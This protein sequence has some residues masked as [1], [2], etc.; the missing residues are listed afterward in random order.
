MKRISFLI[1]GVAL[2]TLLPAATINVSPGSNTLKTA[3]TNAAAGDILVL[4]DGTYYDSSVKPAVPLT[5]QAAE[6]TSP[7]I[8]LS[9]RI[10]IKADFTLQ[11]V[12]VISSGEVIRMIADE[13]PYSVTVTDCNM[14]GCPNYFIRAYTTTAEAPYI[15]SLTVTNCLF[16]MHKDGDTGSPRAIA[17]SKMLTQLASLSVSYCTFDGDSSGAARF[18][19]H[20][21]G[22]GIEE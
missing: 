1:L 8:Q 7:V 5:I 12:N 13:T 16:T 20:H 15:H 17:A 6:G 11:G 18:I 3:V 10:E 19:Y 2:C 22:E 4:T 21:P 9:S 14:S